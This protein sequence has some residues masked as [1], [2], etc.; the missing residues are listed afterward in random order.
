M[1]NPDELVIKSVALYVLKFVFLSW[2]VL[3]GDEKQFSLP[4]VPFELL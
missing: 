3:L 4:H 2:K 1:G